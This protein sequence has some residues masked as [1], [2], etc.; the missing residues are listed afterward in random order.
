LELEQ[1]TKV[2]TERNEMVEAV[3]QVGLVVLVME[4]VELKLVQVD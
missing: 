3:E 4:P 1:L 2:S